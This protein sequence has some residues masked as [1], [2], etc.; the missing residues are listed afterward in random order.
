MA[1][2]RGGRITASTSYWVM[3]G[4]T[5]R[6]GATGGRRRGTFEASGAEGANG[7]GDGYKCRSAYLRRLQAADDVEGCVRIPVHLGRR[8]EK[9]DGWSLP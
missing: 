6:V 2:G 8:T 1:R 9:A 7:T 3:G 4:G 5:I